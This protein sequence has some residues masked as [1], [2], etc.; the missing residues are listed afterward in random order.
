MRLDN[1]NREELTAEKLELTAINHNGEFTYHKLMMGAKARMD[2]YQ[3]MPTPTEMEQINTLEA[4]ISD[5]KLRLK[6]IDILLQ[7]LRDKYEN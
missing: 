2:Q 7:Y 4:Q 5:N 1:L 6:Q 3:T